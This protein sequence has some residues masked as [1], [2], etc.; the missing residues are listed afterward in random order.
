MMH[1][2]VTVISSHYSHCTKQEIPLNGG[3]VATPR[4]CL[5][6]IVSLDV[7]NSSGTQST[8]DRS[9]FII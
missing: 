2:S 9:S 5:V 6:I 4:R 3:T 7:W 8:D 1:T